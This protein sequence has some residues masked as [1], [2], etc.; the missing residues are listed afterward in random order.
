MASAPQQASLPLFYNALEPLSSGAHAAFKLRQIDRAPFLVNQHAIPV[1]VDEFIHVQRS[2][3]IVFTAGDDAVPIALMGLNEGVN[4]FI[5]EDGKLS[6]PSIYVP[7][8]VRRYPFMLAR[9]TPDAQ[10]LSLCFDS[11]ADVIG[12]FDEGEP[13]F[14]DGKPTEIVQNILQFNEMFE[15]AGARTG[16]FMRELRELGLLIEGEISIQPEGAP[17][18]FVY[19]GFQM[20]SEEKLNELRGDQLRK[21]QKNGMLPLLYAHL[22]SLQLMPQVFDRQNRVGKVPLPQF[23]S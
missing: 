22:F 17:Q 7:A 6:D 10:E 1:T 11:T 9:L 20:V 21:I 5:D 8:Y 3:P 14:D 19:R 15:E 16:N 18:P 4:V 23:A 12:A 13:L 2:M